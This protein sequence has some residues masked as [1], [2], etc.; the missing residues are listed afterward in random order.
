MANAQGLSY[1]HLTDLALEY[2]TSMPFACVLLQRGADAPFRQT[3][4]EQRVLTSVQIDRLVEHGSVAQ[5]HAG[6]FRAPSYSGKRRRVLN[7]VVAVVGILATLPVML[8]VALMVKLT[9][10]GPVFFTQTRVGLDRRNPATPAGN[11]RRR[12]NNGGKP[13]TIYKFR[14]M[15]VDGGKSQVW[16]SPDDPR[17]TPVGRILRKTRLDELPQLLNVLQGDMNI[18]GPRPE[19]PKIFADLRAQIPDYEKRQRVLPGITGW[20]QINHHYDTSVEDVRTKLA[21]DLEYVSRRQSA[22]HDLQ[23][24]AKTMPVMVFKKGAR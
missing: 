4:A 15:F 2:L 8:V 10:R 9:S 21:F 24:M 13:F 23:I 19:Q 12:T 17:I 7:V 18:V 22:G 1:Q 16:A 20:A 14:T 11:C 6:L 3:Y 5:M